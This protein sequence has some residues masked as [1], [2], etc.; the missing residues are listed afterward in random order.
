MTILD[1]NIKCECRMQVFRMDL[2]EWFK[3]F[4]ILKMYMTLKFLYNVRFLYV[5]L[6]HNEPNA[7]KFGI[8]SNIVVIELKLGVFN[9]N[10]IKVS[11]TYFTVPRSRGSGTSRNGR[12]TP[13]SVFRLE[14]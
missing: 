1:L 3:Y 11:Q 10:S 6:K 9:K 5:E 14:Y 7:Q 12:L 13:N 8:N 2:A 4:C